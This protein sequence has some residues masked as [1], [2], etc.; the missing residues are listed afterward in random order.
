MSASLVG[1][2]MCIR[3]RPCT[4]QPRSRG[5]LPPRR[6]ELPAEGDSANG[7]PGAATAATAEG[8]E[9]ADAGSAK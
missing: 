9:A 5:R 1:S 7:D 6:G 3:D 8:A 2:E 4:K